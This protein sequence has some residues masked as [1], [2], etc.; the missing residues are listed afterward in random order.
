MGAMKRHVAR[1]VR[2][3]LA[4]VDAAY[5]VK[6]RSRPNVL[7]YTDSRGQNLTGRLGKTGI[8]SYVSLLR[9]RYRVTQSVCPER[10]TTIVDFLNFARGFD[11]SRFD[12]I[13]LHCGIVD[14]SPRPLS[15]IARLRESKAGV[16]GF[17][18]LFAA[19]AE[20]HADPW[21][22][23]YYGEPTINLYSPEYLRDV[24]A[25]QLQAMPQLIWINSNRI[26]GDWTG[27]YTKGRPANIDEVVTSFDALMAE[28][29]PQVVDLRNWSDDEVKRW[30]IDNIHFT[31]EGFH[32]VAD[33]VDSAIQS[34]IAPLTHA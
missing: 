13:V 11:L 26:L 22:V 15:N 10:H 31:R 28:E 27:N 30:T 5:R 8:G 21:P 32:V 23:E 12:A 6:N 2:A 14:F 29:L 3:A 25:P 9:T 7:I 19:N 24:I 34:R 16:P 17:G 4:G 20:Y 18:E 1:A 33:A